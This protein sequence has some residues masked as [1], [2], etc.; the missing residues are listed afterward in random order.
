MEKIHNIK[1]IRAD[2]PALWRPLDSCDRDFK[3]SNLS[4]PPFNNAFVYL[5][6]A[7]TAQKPQVLLDALARAYT[8]ECANVHRGL[9]RRSE[10][11][12]TKFE[13]SRRKIAEF[14]HAKSPQEIVFT[15][16]ATEGI[17]LVA[18][19]YVDPRI[20]PGDEIL[21]TILEHHANFVPWQQLCARK[22]AKLKIAPIN[23]TGE[24]QMQETLNLISPRTKFIAVSQMSNVLGTVI[25]LKALIAVARQRE[26]PVLVD[27]CQSIAHFRIDIQDLGCDFLVFSTHKLYGP[28][29]VG[30]LYGRY[31]LLE[32]MVPYNL[33][34]SMISE[35]TIEKTLFQAPPLRFEAGTPAIAQVIA[36]SPLLE[37]LDKIDWYALHC[38]ENELLLYATKRVEELG[39]FKIIGTHSD[40]SSIISFVHEGAHP[41][42]IGVIADHCGVAIRVGH[43]CAQPLLKRFNLNSV[44]RASIGVYNNHHDI[45]ELIAALAKV[46]KF[47]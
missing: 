3:A 6:S 26:I 21:I 2:F 32:K 47:F 29:G 12:T 1:Q 45:D 20:N 22:G 38:H 39:R 36:L 30:V 24:L 8:Y 4:T 44:A 37:Y 35:V 33:G 28:N 9:Y 41:Q 43:N 42:D 34:G 19:S 27:A 14:I 23:D 17:N 5:D 13:D 7:A 10:L 40:K 46:N 31:E 18:H 16:N 11:A 25:D 15:K